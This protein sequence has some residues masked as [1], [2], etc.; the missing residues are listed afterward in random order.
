VD[1]EIDYYC[2]MRVLLIFC[3]IVVMS[4]DVK[5]SSSVAPSEGLSRTTLHYAEGFTVHYEGGNKLVEVKRPFQGAASGYKYLLVPRGEMVTSQQPDVRIIHIPIRSIVCTSTTH[6]PLLDYLN[7]SEKLIGFP[8]TDYISSVTVRKRIDEGHVTDLGVDNSINLER[9]AVL[10]PEIVMGYLMSSDYGQFKK[11]EELNIP[12]VLNAEYLE[13][14]PLGR[15]EWIKFVAL[16]FDKEKQADSI[17]HV[18]EKSYVDIRKM[19]DTTES[20]PTVLCGNVYGDTWF[21]PGGKNYAATI[22]KDAGCNYM[23]SENLSD[24]FL[25]LSF[26]SAYEKAHDADLWIGVG[27]YASLADIAKADHRYTLFKPFV[28]KTVYNYDARK[29]PRG[30]N[31]LLELGYLR[32]DIIL[33]DLVKISHPALLPGHE[34]YFYRHLE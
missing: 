30:G 14:H 29:G 1:I 26:E 18:I 6:I 4:C 31:E 13:K 11:M 5:K 23:W 28:Q 17:F 21:L 27:P 7:E 34:L 3:I 32:P 22:L 16:F 15:A 33:K 12:V 24:G 9:L 8:S 2:T 20:R 25:E 19:V 10:E